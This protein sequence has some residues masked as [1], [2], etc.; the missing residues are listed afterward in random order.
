MSAA[1]ALNVNG[2]PREMPAGATLADL[3]RELGL[4]GKRIAVEVNGTVVSRSRHAATALAA[5]D[6]VEI[7]GAV[8]GG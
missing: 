4:E 3:V 1:L 6:R 8:G 2:R 7:V 5:G